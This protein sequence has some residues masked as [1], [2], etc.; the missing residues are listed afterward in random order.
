MRVTDATQARL[1][2]ELKE[3]KVFELAHA[4]SMAYLDGL[5]ERNVFPTS[6]AIADLEVFEEE[7]PEG[8]T[9]AIDVIEA[10]ARYGAPA[11]TAQL[12]GRYFGFV[13][14][15]ATPA[16]L[17]AKSLAT[18]WDQNAAMTV[19]S[20]VTAR[21]EEVVEG[22][23][24]QIFGL[25]QDTAVGFVSGTAL[26]TFAGLAAGRYRLLERL[27][28]DVNARGLF[29]APRLR[30]VTGEQAHS[31]VDRAIAM[32]GLGDA[33]VE[34]VPVDEQGRLMADELPPLDDRCLVVLQAGNVNSGSFDPLEEVCAV[35]R[36]AG[37][38]VHVD[39][40]FG[41]WAAASPELAHLTRGLALADSWATD[42]HKTLNTP[43]DSGVIMCRD[44]DALATALR[45][46]GSYLVIGDDREGIL[47]TPDASRRS[48]VIELWATLKALGATGLEEL[49]TGLHHR[50]VQ[51]ADE[52]AAI[53]GFEVLNDVVFNQVLV[54][55]E[56]DAV[57]TAT[58][59][60][61]QEL[62]E[63][64]VGGSRWHGRA[65][66]RVSVSSWA[67]T[68]QDITRSVGSFEAA[69]ADVMPGPA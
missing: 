18:Y 60:R 24:G 27:D 17:A 40:A 34:R 55:C 41:L 61:A 1:F 64:W 50:A 66:I 13:N 33:I 53:P 8:P 2:D 56:S 39:G 7:F 48:R 43:Y 21:L 25:P 6:E 9:A 37:A 63:C 26:A 68:A 62:R 44:R 36:E 15:G 59:Q 20:P 46:S 32:L 30:V 4:H 47:F 11:T 5:T 49:T 14:G 3:R 19:T 67:T 38:W 54:A 16:G 52:I 57:T 12:G 23:L 35:A 10:L 69:L 65:V 31:T 51:F 58:L 42:G 22:W 28:W 29:D 45:M